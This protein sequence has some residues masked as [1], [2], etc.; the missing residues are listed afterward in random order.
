VECRHALSSIER[1]QSLEDT[2]TS[3]IRDR[4][5]GIAR[6]HPRTPPICRF[7]LVRCVIGLVPK[8]MIVGFERVFINLE[9][10]RVFYDEE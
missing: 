5:K 1:S 6:P 3:M 8:N 10:E 4:V 9:G 7:K 2:H